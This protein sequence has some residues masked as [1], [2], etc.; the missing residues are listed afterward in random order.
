[1]KYGWKRKGLSLLLTAVLLATSIPFSPF[2]GLTV[3]AAEPKNTETVTIGA[4][5]HTL[6]DK[7]INGK[8]GSAAVIV[9]NDAKLTLQNVTVNAAQGQSAIYIEKNATLIIE[10]TVTVKGG[11]AY[12]TEQN[13]MFG[14]FKQYSANGA[15][16]GIEVPKGANLTIQG[17][18][19]LH[20]TGGN[21]A[22][23]L[24]GASPLDLSLIH[25]FI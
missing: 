10:G 17:S 6:S 15:G 19:T 11:N 4:G 7:T 24:F 3:Q 20:A 2:A 16:A 5:E 12:F 14:R 22:D 1:M 13:D 21:A 8:E 25:I 9:K 18:G 23:G